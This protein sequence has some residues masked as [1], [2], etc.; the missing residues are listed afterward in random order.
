MG[1]DFEADMRKMAAGPKAQELW[2]IMKPMQ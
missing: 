2:A 1:D